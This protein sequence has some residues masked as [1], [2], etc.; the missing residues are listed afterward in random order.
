MIKIGVAGA[1]HLGKIHIKLLQTIP[2]FEL[3]GFYDANAA[4]AKEVVEKFQLKAFPTYEAMLEVCEAVDIVTPTVLHY[5]LAIQAIE[6]GKHVF[7]EKP[8]TDRLDSAQALIKAAKAKN[9]KAQVGHVERFNPAFL[10]LKAQYSDIN[11]LFIESHRLAIFNPRGTDVSVVMDLMI[12]D[13]DIICH[14]V[15]APL[16]S[17]HA[18]GVSLVSSEPDIANVRLAF[19]NNCIANLT[20]S[21]L[22]AKNMRKMRIFSPNAY[23][24]VDFLSKQTEVFTLSD[25]PQ[26]NTFTQEIDLGDAGKRYLRMEMPPVEEVNAIQY[27]LQHFANSIE[28]NTPTAVSF[29]EATR[30]LAIA[31]Q[32]NKAMDEH[33]Q[34]VLKNG[35]YAQK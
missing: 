21:R 4:T 27:E 19:A 30:A 31:L 32:I 13:I 29:E 26:D 22:S 35:T 7:V 9:V 2:Q 6:A 3:C 20:A 8:I 1:G 33:R 18:T 17:L 5:D 34:N 24:G 15:N 14:L 11:P 10:S 28:K 25:M 12:H 16:E 23:Y